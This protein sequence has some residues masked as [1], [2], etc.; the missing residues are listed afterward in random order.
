[1]AS[2]WQEKLKQRKK[3]NEAWIQVCNDP[4]LRKL[5]YKGLVKKLDNTISERTASRMLKVHQRLTRDDYI[6]DGLSW[7]QSQELEKR[8]R[9]EERRIKHLDK[10][11]PRKPEAVIAHCG[12]E[13]RLLFVHYD[14]TRDEDKEAVYRESRKARLPD[15]FDDP[16]DDDQYMGS[17][18]I[19]F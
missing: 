3:D 10:V 14:I 13:L 16:H 1:M 15:S 11:D 8:D 19:P 9:E 6:I 18:F 2:D 7:T 17:S 4:Y 12:E 5:K